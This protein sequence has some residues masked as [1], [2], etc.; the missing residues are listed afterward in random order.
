[1]KKQTILYFVIGIAALAIAASTSYYFLVFLPD[2]ARQETQWQQQR[3]NQNF[4]FSMKQKCQESGE[5]L[6]NDDVKELGRNS[7]FVP[8]YAYNQKLNTCLY[9]SAYVQKDSLQKWIKDSLSNK[10]LVWFWKL[11]DEIVTKDQ[12]N[13][14]VSNEEFNKQKEELFR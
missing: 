7:L 2:Q 1:M 11:N 6:Y 13:L 5:K 12:C 10:D 4:L 14:C 8:E 3:E 9:S